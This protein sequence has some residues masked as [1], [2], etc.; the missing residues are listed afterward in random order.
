MK[1]YPN[2]AKSYVSASEVLKENGFVPAGNGL[3]YSEE[4]LEIHRV[5]I[6][7][8]NGEFYRFVNME[9]SGGVIH[10]VILEKC[11]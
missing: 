3:M 2:V 11:Y 4:S 10:A 7:K 9:H 5:E 1:V 8:K 6:F